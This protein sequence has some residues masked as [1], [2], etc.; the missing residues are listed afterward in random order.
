MSTVEKV[1][2]IVTAVT[3]MSK[4]VVKGETR[5][6]VCFGFRI[7]VREMH[8]N[9]ME[10]QITETIKIENMHKLFMN[11]KSGNEMYISVYLFH[12]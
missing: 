12:K 11:R 2:E 1:R 3:L 9:A 7:N 4:H 5:C 10:R 8:T 6:E